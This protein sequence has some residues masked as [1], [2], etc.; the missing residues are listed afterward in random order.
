MKFG[1]LEI[2][3]SSPRGNDPGAP[4]CTEAQGI[5]IVGVP[6][7]SSR[8]SSAQE[9]I[10]QEVWGWDYVGDSRTVMFISVGFGKRLKWDPTV[11]SRIVTVRGVI[12]V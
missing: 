1:D 2:R 5:R 6:R 7:T 10:L 3:I 8:S 11:P 4:H 9:S 12:Q